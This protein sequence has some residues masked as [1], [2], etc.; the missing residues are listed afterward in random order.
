MIDEV[1]EFIR[2]YNN[3]WDVVIKPDT[4]LMFDLGLESYNIIEMCCELEDYFSIVISVS[5]IANIE[6]IEDI[7]KYIE[8]YRMQEQCVLTFEKEV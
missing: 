4:K 3:I 8:N 5:D 7:A 2:K 6:T 1:I